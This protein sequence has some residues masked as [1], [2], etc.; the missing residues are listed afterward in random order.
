M[1]KWYHSNDCENNDYR[2]KIIS[3]VYLELFL[4]CSSVCT[5]SDFWC[6]SWSSWTNFSLDQSSLRELLG[7]WCK[8]T[9]KTVLSV[10]C[11]QKL[12]VLLKWKMRVGIIFDFDG[13]P[14]RGF[15]DSNLL[16]SFSRWVTWTILKVKFSLWV[17]VSA[18]FGFVLIMGC[19]LYGIKKNHESL[20][21]RSCCILWKCFFFSK[22]NRANNLFTR[23]PTEQNMTTLKIYPSQLSF[24]FVVTVMYRQNHI[25]DSV[26]YF[27]KFWQIEPVFRRLA[28]NI[29]CFSSFLNFRFG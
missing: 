16:R 20:E 19:L 3:T 13:P 7:G 24:H 27:R 17:T 18:L 25:S 23:Q 22:L 5:P 15:D 6:G 2:F 9:D 11:G 14:Q 4:G 1:N 21:H 12:A 29:E 8:N 28:K 26:N 10:L